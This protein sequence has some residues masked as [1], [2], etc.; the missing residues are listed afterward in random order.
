MERF[1]RNS[2]VYQHNDKCKVAEW[3]NVNARNG[4]NIDAFGIQVK[5]DSGYKIDDQSIGQTE[6]FTLICDGDNTV[7]YS[8]Y[9]TGT[10]AK[11]FSGCK[12]HHNPVSES[13]RLDS[14]RN[15]MYTNVK[16]TNGAP[17]SSGNSVQVKCIGDYEFEGNSGAFW[18]TCADG[19]LK[20]GKQQ[21][22]TT[23]TRC[24]PKSTDDDCAVNLY[25]LNLSKTSHGGDNF[26]LHSEQKITAWCNT[27]WNGVSK[28]EIKCAGKKHV[29]KARP[30]GSS[31]E[32]W[33]LDFDGCRG[34]RVLEADEDEKI[35]PPIIV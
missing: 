10:E 12:P 23:F 6:E 34:D 28:I 20:Y 31:K 3:M 13:C 25:A 27:S 18:V 21:Y 26:V 9:R 4:K 8:K 11:Y 24:T 1:S 5:C 16:P 14:W 33:D 15:I 17:L 7:K 35:E 2:C 32:E 19:T 22:G 30:S 29:L